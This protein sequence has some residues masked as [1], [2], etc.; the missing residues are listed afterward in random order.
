M[1]MN[2]KRYLLVFLALICFAAGCQQQQ[3]DFFVTTDWLAGKAADEN[4]VI[5][6]AN[7]KAAYAAAHIQ[8]AVNVWYEDF[9]DT[10]LQLNLLSPEVLAQKLGEKGIT[11]KETIVIYG[12]AP[13]YIGRISWMLDYLGCKDIHILDGGLTKW[14]SES[15]QTTADNATI[16]PATFDYAVND[17]VY[18]TTE[19]VVA[20]LDDPAAVIVDVRTDEEYNGWQLSKEPRPGHITGAVHLPITSWFNAD[21]TIK[22]A[23]E[24]GDMFSAAGVTKDKNVIFYCTI[25]GRSGLGPELAI[26]YL[27]YKAASN[28]DGSIREWG[29][30]ES[31]PMESGFKNISLLFPARYINSAITAGKNLK[32]I[33]CRSEDEYKA[34]H[35]PG[36]INLQWGELS[37]ADMPKNLLPDYEVV[38]IL[39]EHGIGGEDNSSLAGTTNEIVVIYTT[40]EGSWGADGRLFWTLEYMGH[41]NVHVL[42]GGWK[43]WVDSGSK[44]ETTVNTP[45][46][47]TYDGTVNGSVLATKDYVKAH[48]NDSAVSIVDSRTDEEWEGAALY[49]EARGGRIPGAVHYNYDTYFDSNWKLSGSELVP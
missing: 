40:V 35:I 23:S 15:R 27:G 11:G 43:A 46:A 29:Q 5:I 19:E 39:G 8:G 24:L 44:V 18:A 1:L 32:I 36:A 13:F 33:D 21:A 22:T 45:V 41:K 16:T 28:Y 26:K 48:L 25:G 10:S 20:A 6:D 38:Q 2:V 31:R 49:G 12:E 42:N 30:D 4:I 47:V 17:A 14:K 37:Y 3:A 9:N 7:Q 34:G